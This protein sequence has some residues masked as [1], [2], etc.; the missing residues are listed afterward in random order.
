MNGNFVGCGEE[1][2]ASFAIDAVPI[3]TASYGPDLIL[4]SEFTGLSGFSRRSG[5]I[6]VSHLT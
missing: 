1:R 5:G 2:T 3:V 6:W 4:T